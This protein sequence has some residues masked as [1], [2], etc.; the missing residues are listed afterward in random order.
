MQLAQAIKLPWETGSQTINYP[1]SLKGFAFQG[2]KGNLGSI[3]SAAIPLIFGFAGIGLLIMI[4]SAG[5]TFLTS[6]GDAKKLEKGKQQLTY[7]IVGFLI[8]FAAYWIVQLFGI[9]FG[10]DVFTTIFK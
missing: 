5:F 3:L 10:L 7:A 1:T 9:I 6:A 2:T 8:I 4:L